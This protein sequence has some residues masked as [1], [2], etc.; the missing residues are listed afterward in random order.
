MTAHRDLR[1]EFPQYDAPSSQITEAPA[2]T[3]L[4]RAVLARALR[5]LQR[6]SESP[7]PDGGD[8]DA[9]DIPFTIVWFSS[10]NPDFIAVCRMADY[11]PRYVLRKAAPILAKARQR[12]N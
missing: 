11:E 9:E 8:M 4:W 1:S 2:C 12:V 6:I 3:R 7:I 5:D 10:D